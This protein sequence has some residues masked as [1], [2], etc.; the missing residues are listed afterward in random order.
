M[1][2][3]KTKSR[4][5]AKKRYLLADPHLMCLLII[6]L[7]LIT[8]SVVYLWDVIISSIEVIAILSGSLLLVLVGLVGNAYTFYGFF[9]IGTD[10]IQISAFPRKTY[11]LDFSDVQIIGIDYDIISGKKQFWIYFSKKVIPMKYYHRMLKLP[12]SK[13]VIKISFSKKRFD[14]LMKCL[15][16]RLKKDLGRSYSTIRLYHADK[17]D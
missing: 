4:S 7:C 12:Y 16:E 15:P 10:Y 13:D 17:T 3:I 8:F 1:N 14:I 5:H 6:P 9:S 11:R 2:N